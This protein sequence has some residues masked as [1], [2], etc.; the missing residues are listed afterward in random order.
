M[1][2]GRSLRVTRICRCTSSP[3]QLRLPGCHWVTWAKGAYRSAWR[4]TLTLD[5]T[6]RQGNR[7]HAVREETVGRRLH[8]N[9]RGHRPVRRGL[10]SAASVAALALFL[11]GCSG[12]AGA[13]SAV[14]A[15]AGAGHTPAVS[16]TASPPAGPGA[17]VPTTGT[18]PT[19]ES[20]L[21]TP[22]TCAATLQALA[23]GGGP[24]IQ[25][26]VP[27]EYGADGTLLSP[28]HENSSFSPQ[29]TALFESI[30]GPMP[31]PDDPYRRARWTTAVGASSWVRNDP[32]TPADQ[33]CIRDQLVDP[34]SLP[35]PAPAPTIPD[36]PV[37]PEPTDSMGAINPQRG[38][39]AT[40]V[41]T[42]KLPA[43]DAFWSERA[44]GE[45]T[46]C[47]QAMVVEIPRIIDGHAA[48]V[49]A[50]FSRA[51][52]LFGFMR[53]VAAMIPSKSSGAAGMKWLT[54]Q[55]TSNMGGE[56]AELVGQACLEWTGQ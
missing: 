30:L 10:R 39:S 22:S 50:E 7:G 33:V 23:V 6:A 42:A 29:Q 3:T 37:P 26:Y 16:A 19:L 34:S 27:A 15:A 31:G 17:S 13:V 36:A 18:E 43:L 20:A 28:A 1:P 40:D 32:G 49:Q 55:N 12:S 44:G 9:H 4:D 45:L 2:S 54:T 24:S 25:G 56:N 53:R 52:G 48:A 21:E 46:P 35:K 38:S 11:A 14:R 51:P 8:R 5:A 41:I 47:F